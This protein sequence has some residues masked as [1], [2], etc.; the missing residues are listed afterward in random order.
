ML[1]EQE[2][3]V[4]QLVIVAM[5]LL[6]LI[7][8]VLEFA[9]G[10]P[11]AAEVLEAKFVYW[12]LENEQ[13]HVEHIVDNEKYQMHPLELIGQNIEAEGVDG[14]PIDVIHCFILILQWMAR[15]DGIVRQQEQAAHEVARERQLQQVYHIINNSLIVVSR[16]LI[17]AE[18]ES[19]VNPV[20]NH[21]VE[22]ADGQK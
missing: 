16:R 4:Y 9:A 13:R 2:F 14:P 1:V 5:H 7:N 18:E 8:F 20:N 11:Q 19:F 15:Q 6:I 10:T 21:E 17:E 3:Q 12:D 22:K